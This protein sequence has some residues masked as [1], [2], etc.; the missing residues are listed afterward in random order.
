MSGRYR[1]VREFWGRVIQEQNPEV[2]DYMKVSCFGYGNR[3][4][5]KD[6]SYRPCKPSTYSHKFH[7]VH[8][9][10]TATTARGTMRR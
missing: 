9:Q 4:R 3:Q 1:K 6:R 5:P 8:V 2:K 10:V 7:V